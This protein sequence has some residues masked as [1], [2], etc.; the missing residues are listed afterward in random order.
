MRAFRAAVEQLAVWPALPPDAA[1]APEPHPVWGAGAGEGKGGLQANADRR[2]LLRVLL[3]S[4]D[5]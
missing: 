1:P 3:S 4:G 2:E 5:K